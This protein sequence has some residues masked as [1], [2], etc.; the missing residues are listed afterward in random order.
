MSTTDNMRKMIKLMEVATGANPY[1][2]VG[3]REERKELHEARPLG[4]WELANKKFTLVY[5]K[6]TYILVSQG[7]GEEQKLKAKTPQE[8]TQELVKK[9][10]REF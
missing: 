2:P 1:A 9:G 5:D 6:G 8:A 3:V 10:Y 7:T 4:P